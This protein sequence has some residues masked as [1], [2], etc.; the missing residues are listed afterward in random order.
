[1][2]FDMIPIDGLWVL[3]QS[4]LPSVPGLDSLAT[5]KAWELVSSFLM[6]LAL[7]AI[8]R[9]TW[10]DAQ[11]AVAAFAACYLYALVALLWRGDIAFDGMSVGMW[12]ETGTKIFALTIP[13][14]YGWWKPTG[15]AP[16][17]EAATG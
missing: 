8:I 7:A 16:K 5:L 6:P 13:I 3:A 1:M 9:Q 12:L 2:I 10:G 17:I 14:Y 15:V 4:E 11:K